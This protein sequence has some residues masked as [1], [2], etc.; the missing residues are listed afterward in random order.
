MNDKYWNESTSVGFDFGIDF[1]DDDNDDNNTITTDDDIKFTTIAEDTTTST[2]KQQQ[3]ELQTKCSDLKISQT[4]AEEQIQKCLKEIERRNADDDDGSNARQSDR[5]LTVKEAVNCLTKG[6][7]VN[8]RRYKSLADKLKLLDTAIDSKDSNAII[9]TVVHLKRTVKPSI[10]NTE[11][12]KRSIAADHYV[13]YLRQYDRYDELYDLLAMLCRHQELAFMAISQ[14]IGSGVN[15]TSKINNLKS[16]LRKHMTTGGQDMMFWQHLITDQI[17]LLEQQ[18][19]IEADDQRQERDGLNP[20]F[21]KIPRPTLTNLSVISTLYYCCLYH[22]DLADNHFASPSNLTK[23]FKLNQKQFVWTAVTALA[24]TGRW[25][26]IDGLFQHKSWLGS[27]RIKCCI[28]LP[29]LVKILHNNGASREVTHK[30]LQLIDN[31]ETKADLV[32]DLK[33]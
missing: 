23:N 25:D 27:K 33:I 20:E 28:S 22:Y 11:L 29:K 7:D 6:R 32:R 16:C 8:L 30:Y 9:S 26:Q 15:I 5:Q 4:L 21:A 31:S 1:D 12:I 2:D 24:N 18:L 13:S 14:A 19:P 3:Q 17:Q 10:F